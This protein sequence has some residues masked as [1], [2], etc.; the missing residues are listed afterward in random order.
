[1]QLTSVAVF[2]RA[3]DGTL[4]QK[5]GTAGCVS[6]TGTGGE[7]A[8]GR[9][10][11][12]A[13]SVAVSP[14]GESAYVASLD[15]NAVAVFDRAPDGTLTQKPGTA[16]CVQVSG[17]AGCAD[18]RALNHPA[19][20]A[21]SPDGESAYVASELSSAVA[22]FDRAPDGTLT[23][24]PGTAGCVSE[25]GTGG[26][27]A[28]GTAL[29]NPLS[30]AVSPDGESAYVATADAVAVFDRDPDT[31]ALTQ[32]DGAA[33]CVSETG[34]G[35]ECA[36][37]RA[38]VGAFSVAVSPDGESA[39]V[40]SL[41]SNAVAVFDRDPD[42][43]ALTQE[44]GAAGCVSETG[45]GG[46]CANGRALEEANSV[47]VS[48]AGDSAYVASRGSNAAAVFDR[49]PLSPPTCDALAERTPSGVPLRIALPCMGEGELT[50]SVR[51][52]PSDGTIS[53]LDPSAG[54][55]TYTPDTGFS[56]ADTFTYRA[57][58]AGGNSNVATATIEVS[59]PPSEFTLG[60]IH[61]VRRGKARVTIEIEGPS[62]GA[63]ELDGPQV[64]QRHK[65]ATGERSVRLNVTATGSKKRKLYKTGK[66]QGFLRDHL[67]PRR[68]R[69]RN[70]VG[71]GEPGQARLSRF[72]RREARRRSGRWPTA[73]RSSGARRCRTRCRR[74]RCPG[75]ARR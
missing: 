60:S 66:G 45:T 5:P 2:D 35:G 21:V 22:V 59:P 30:V 37:G 58:N 63:L 17:G 31:G 25:T 44:D 16:G 57:S 50:H 49:G 53:G 61:K 43:G 46:Q 14:D 65:R 75:K 52:A 62:A 10:L 18:G 33:G 3:P 40:A 68:R 36:D 54:T 41:N 24:K 15:N 47:T 27:C 29:N 56:G 7:C 8:D 23:Q 20:V 70:Q 42:T 55:L 67:H 4:T 28:D 12:G 34:T 48:P 71:P 6:E 26:Q 9:A 38:L 13:L 73:T 19:S 11:V 1:L 64:K 72:P 39:Y 32:K 74:L 69:A 51:L